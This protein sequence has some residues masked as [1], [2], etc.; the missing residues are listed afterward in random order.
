MFSSIFIWYVYAPEQWQPAQVF[1]PMII[2]LSLVSMFIN[3]RWNMIIGTIIASLLILTLYFFTNSIPRD[4]GQLLQIMIAVIMVVFSTYVGQSIRE[5]NSQLHNQSNSAST[6]A[7]LYL[8]QVR[9]LI[10]SEFARGYRY[11][12]PIV[13]IRMNGLIK[14]EKTKKQSSLDEN[15]QQIDQQMA[16]FLT[17]N[18]RVTDILV[19]LSA[20]N[21]FL[22]I[23]PGINRDNASH[24][25]NRLTELVT[26]ENFAGFTHTIASFPHDGRSFE[27]LLSK[28]GVMDI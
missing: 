23:C 7:I 25:I 26:H 1:F 19:H 13:M 2:A 4:A 15:T 10:E 6:D 11:N 16:A 5:L 21:D 27:A 17:Q 12:Y 18:L 3:T 14:E 20:V 8:H 28:L 24:M 22:L 9:P